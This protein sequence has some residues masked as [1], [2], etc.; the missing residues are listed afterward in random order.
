MH[1]LYPFAISQNCSRIIRDSGLS[2]HNNVNSLTR[3]LFE[4]Q[5]RKINRFKKSLILLKTFAVF[6]SAVKVI[7][8][9][10]FS[11]FSAFLILHSDQMSKWMTRPKAPLWSFQ[12]FVGLEAT[13]NL[14]WGDLFLGWS[15]NS[16]ENLYHL[17]VLVAP[18]WPWSKRILW[19]R[20]ARFEWLTTL[21]I[22]GYKLQRSP[23][24]DLGTMLRLWLWLWTVPTAVMRRKCMTPW[25]I[26]Q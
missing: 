6:F 23:Q 8:M 13:L 5:M 19:S 12:G 1:P 9:L 2:I 18:S 26:W 24:N 14:V 17:R 11:P 22:N 15:M 20:K 25:V 10:L 21:F 16:S 3:Q 4:I 7:C